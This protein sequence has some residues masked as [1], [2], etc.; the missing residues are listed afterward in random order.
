MRGLR[1][2]VSLD[3]GGNF[4]GANGIKEGDV[5]AEDRLEVELTNTL[6]GRLSS[7]N[8]DTHIDVSAEEHGH[9]WREEWIRMR[10]RGRKMVRI[11]HRYK[12]D[13]KHPWLRHYETSVQPGWPCWPTGG[14]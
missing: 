2:G 12:L 5:L 4:T 8:P 7:V 3:A 10:D 6:S 14:H 13:R 11:A 9:A 1:T